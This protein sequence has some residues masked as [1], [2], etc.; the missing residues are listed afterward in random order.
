MMRSAQHRDGLGVPPPQMQ[1]GSRFPLQVLGGFVPQ[2]PVGFPLQSLTLIANYRN[3]GH[4]VLKDQ[5]DTAYPPC[6]SDNLTMHWRRVAHASSVI[7]ATGLD[8]P[9]SAGVSHDLDGTRYFTKPPPFS[10]VI[11]SPLNFSPTFRRAL[12]NQ[13]WLQ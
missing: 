12:P 7:K 4:E 11:G 6:N 3:S 5:Y 8:S 9:L 13:I 2:P 1:A 10:E